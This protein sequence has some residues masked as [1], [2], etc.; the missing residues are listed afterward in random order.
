MVYM[1][2]IVSSIRSLLDEHAAPYSFMEH[3]AG[4]TSEEM[5]PSTKIWTMT[6]EFLAT[7]A[8]FTHSTTVDAT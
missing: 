2:P 1:H 4:T 5:D 6:V 7:Q 8:G 3:E